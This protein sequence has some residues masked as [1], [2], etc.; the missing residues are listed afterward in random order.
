MVGIEAAARC[1]RDLERKGRIVEHL[2]VQHLAFP[3][4]TTITD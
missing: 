1:L 3:T 2:G 4:W